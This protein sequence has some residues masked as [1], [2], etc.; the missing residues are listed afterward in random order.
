MLILKDS[1]NKVLAESN[2]ELI[3]VGREDENTVRLEVEEV[4]GYHG[5]FFKA[6]DIWVFRDNFST[7]GSFYNG[8]SLRSGQIKLVK[9]SDIVRLASFT[10][11]CEV[12]DK[13]EL[14]SRVIAFKGFDLIKNFEIANDGLKINAEDIQDLNSELNFSRNEIGALSFNTTD[15]VIVNGQGHS[16][17][18]ALLDQDQ[19][20]IGDYSFFVLYGEIKVAKPR[21][22]KGNNSEPAK[23]FVFDNGSSSFAGSPSN[24]S[25]GSSVASFAGGLK[26]DQN[27]QVEDSSKGFSKDKKERG[28][29]RG[30]GLSSEPEQE[31]PM[32]AGIKT[33]E[34]SMSQ[35]LS[36]I[37]DHEHNQSEMKRNRIFAALGFVTLVSL[38]SFLLFAASLF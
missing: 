2:S 36:S 26:G 8:K 28:S 31:Q 12:T 30:F 3:S 23:P 6:E 32:F 5:I 15:N 37:A 20:D 9:D 11:R 34:M 27:T 17:K 10:L 24:S 25:V 19:I 33:S 7:N 16:G 29:K 38:V 21:N 35:K 1:S 4:S 18:M 22:Y 13:V 14:K